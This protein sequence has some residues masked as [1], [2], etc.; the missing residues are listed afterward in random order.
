MVNLMS[1]A[2]MTKQDLK[3][4]VDAQTE[5]LSARSSVIA[6]LQSQLNVATTSNDVVDSSGSSFRSNG[7]TSSETLAEKIA[8][9]MSIVHGFN[10]KPEHVAKT[11]VLVHSVRFHL[12]HP[13]SNVVLDDEYQIQT[14]KQDST[15]LTAPPVHVHEM[16]ARRHGDAL[17]CRCG[18][19]ES[20]LTETEKDLGDMGDPSDAQEASR[21]AILAQTR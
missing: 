21:S 6:R 16:K 5:E 18:K 4:K 13:P 1:T 17:K 9:W 7:V 3:D 20:D 15:E 8:S 12:I 19:S 11:E 10:I 2:K 14:L